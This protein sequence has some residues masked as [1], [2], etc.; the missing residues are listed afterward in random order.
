MKVRELVE[1]CSQRINY[2]ELEGNFTERLNT[3]SKKEILKKC[4]DLNVVDFNI[5]T[6]PE[7]G[8]VFKINFQEEELWYE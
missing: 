2:Y 1:S 5:V 6:N 7:F 3:I 8:V 4:G